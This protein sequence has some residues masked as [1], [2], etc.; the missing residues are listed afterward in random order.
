M[1]RSRPLHSTPP[2]DGRLALWA[3]CS[4]G[5]NHASPDRGNQ[6]G[7]SVGSTRRVRADP[8][9]KASCGRAS[10]GRGAPPDSAHVERARV[11]VAV[12]D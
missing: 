12:R 9:T 8:I 6:R 1:R 7:A 3:W 4:A 5:E 2:L 11:I 10:H